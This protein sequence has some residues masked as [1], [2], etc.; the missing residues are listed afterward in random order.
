[1]SNTTLNTAVKGCNH[2]AASMAHTRITTVVSHL[3][4]LHNEEKS[5]KHQGNELQGGHV[6]NSGRPWVI[7]DDYIRKIC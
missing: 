6:P 3:T 4:A 1:M 2:A 7:N 5:H